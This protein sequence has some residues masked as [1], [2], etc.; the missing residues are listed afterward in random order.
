M[1]RI[2][3]SFPSLARAIPNPYTSYSVAPDLSGGTE[4][5]PEAHKQ[6]LNFSLTSCVHVHSYCP[7]AEWGRTSS[8]IRKLLKVTIVERDE[9]AAVFSDLVPSPLIMLGM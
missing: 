1:S 7:A 2:V 3:T 8:E 9:Y 6:I 4:G 5:Q